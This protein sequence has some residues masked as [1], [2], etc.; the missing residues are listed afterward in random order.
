M[1]RRG[2]IGRMGGIEAGALYMRQRSS[3]YGVHVYIESFQC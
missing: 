1:R 2:E 3:G